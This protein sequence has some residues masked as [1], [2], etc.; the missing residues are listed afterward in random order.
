MASPL[1]GVETDAEHGITMP[2]PGTTKI[3]SVAEFKSECAINASQ[4]EKSEVA[5]N[6]IGITAERLEQIKEVCE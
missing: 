3:L 2:A 1:A 6:E 4:L 5:A